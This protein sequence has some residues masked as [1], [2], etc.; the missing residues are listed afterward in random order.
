MAHGVEFLSPLPDGSVVYAC[1]GKNV[2]LPWKYSQSEEDV[3]NQVRWYYEGQSESLVAF[4]SRAAF[5]QCQL[6]P[7]GW[8]LIQTQVTKSSVY[9]EF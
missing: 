9:N 1:A 5:C 4:Y 2:R 8:N 7:E 6:S 3:V